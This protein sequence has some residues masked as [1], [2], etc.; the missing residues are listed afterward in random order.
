MERA[1]AAVYTEEAVARVSPARLERR[2]FVKSD[3]GYQITKAIRDLCVFARHN[4][5]K[6]PPF[7]RLDLI[8]CRNVL[9]YM[10]SALQKRILSVFQYALKP[11]GY[12]FLG[13]SES[14]SD[15]S[16]AFS[17]ADQKHR[18][19]VRKAGPAGYRDFRS[20]TDF[21]RIRMPPSRGPPRPAWPPTSAK[22]PRPRCS[23]GM[24]RPPLWSMRI[25]ISCISRETSVPFWRRPQDS[26]AF[27]C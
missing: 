15:Y 25:C 3:H 13:N 22:T 16:E 19:F 20:A 10:G 11:D 21:R 12:L 17:V 27:T 26:P 6:D 4:L 5:A 18:I 14:I 23:T 1:R 2:F 7:S 8:S 9:I 24:R